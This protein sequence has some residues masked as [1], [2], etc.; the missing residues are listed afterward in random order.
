MFVK[1]LIAVSAVAAA[2][3]FSSVAA[4]ADT[5]VSIG[6]GLGGF[7]PG[8][9]YP[10][11]GPGFGFEGHGHHGWHHPRPRP[12]MDYGLSCGQASNVVR[13]AGFRHVRAI[14]CSGPTYSYKAMRHGDAFK[15]KVTFR[16]DIVSVR[17]IY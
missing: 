11:F 17:P 8:Y 10:D 12:V 6:L 4:K 15:V 1:S 14:N 5:T 16:G 3:S 9:D 13:E 2:V 7:D